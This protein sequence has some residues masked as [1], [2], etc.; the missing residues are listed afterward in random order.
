MYR[1]G[2]FVSMNKLRGT[3]QEAVSAKRIK[4]NALYFIYRIYKNHVQVLNNDI[5]SLNPYLRPYHLHP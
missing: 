2:D 4:K 5:K 1:V 3:S